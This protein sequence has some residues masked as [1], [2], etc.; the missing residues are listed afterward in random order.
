MKDET[1]ARIKDIIEWI[2]CIVIALIIAIAFRY[3]VGTPTIVQQPSMFPTLEP[4]QRL[5]LNRWGRTT[6]KMPQKGDI[7][8]FE[9]PSQTVLSTEQIVQNMI[10]YMERKNIEDIN[11][12]VGCVR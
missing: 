9:A 8:T 4:D 6:K 11:G 5:W 7:V 2:V 12:I 10:Q 3:Y 1:K